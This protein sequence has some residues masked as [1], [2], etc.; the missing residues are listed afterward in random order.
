MRIREVAPG[1]EATP[2]CP[3][4]LMSTNH[5]I[6]LEIGG[7]WLRGICLDPVGSVG[8]RARRL[9]PDRPEAAAAALLELWKELG[10]SVNLAVATAPALDEAGRVLHWGSRP[11]W[12]GAPLLDRLR[13]AAGEP[14]LLDD[15]SAAAVA[16]H[17]AATERSFGR[18]SSILI[19]IGTGLGAGAVLRDELWAGARDRALDLGHVPVPLAAGWQCGCGRTGCL[20]AVASGRRLSDLAQAAGLH[21]EELLQQRPTDATALEVLAEMTA[22]IAQGLEILD[23]LLDPDRFILGGGLARVLFQPVADRFS[24]DGGE[25]PLLEATWGTWSGALGVAA[26]LLRRRGV[27]LT[28]L[29]EA[30][31]HT[32]YRVALIQGPNLNL[33]GQREPQHYGLETLPE[34]EGRLRSICSDLG[35]RLLSI[36]S[37]HEAE[38]VD[39]LQSTRGRMDGAIV[40]PA[41]LTAKGY[42]LR[43]ALTGCNVPFVEVHLSNIDA[44]GGWHS[45]SCFADAAI[46]RIS[47]LRGDGYEAA[48][49]ALVQYLQRRDRS[50]AT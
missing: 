45:E 39:W 33:L 50:S 21:V 17:L 29:H 26:E 38:L 48:L 14:F 11:E 7:T 27:R 18:T 43:D 47:G 32:G 15:A 23:R 3:P 19:S 13:S 5:V 10:R 12:C 42:A 46:G 35:C 30:D 31:D 41:A 28:R 44:R 2:L 37:N 6:G 16:E 40:N 1:V 49:R 24:R 8:Q 22:A 4:S 36:Q 9:T 34:L 25:K 20:Q